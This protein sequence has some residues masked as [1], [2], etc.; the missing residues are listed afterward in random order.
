MLFKEAQA[1]NAHLSIVFTL[2]NAPIYVSE[3]QL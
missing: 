1:P 3:V 2:V